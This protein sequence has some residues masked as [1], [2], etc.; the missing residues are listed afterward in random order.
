LCAGGRRGGQGLAAS[1]A[2]ARG[3][4]V[5]KITVR[6]WKHE[7]LLHEN[8]TSDYLE[9]LISNSI[10]NGRRSVPTQSC[11]SDHSLPQTNPT[12][13]LMLTRGVVIARAAGGAMP[14]G[15]TTAKNAVAFVDP[16]KDSIFPTTLAKEPFLLWHFF[17]SLRI[18]RP[19]GLEFDRPFNSRVRRAINRKFRS[20]RAHR[21]SGD[22]IARLVQVET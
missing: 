17:C 8:L 16:F 2:K 20:N 18:F 13:A 10:G 12:F 1:R 21:T 4:L 11:Y 9:K 19:G 14:L 22:R 5:L 3:W 6:T 7:L 15:M